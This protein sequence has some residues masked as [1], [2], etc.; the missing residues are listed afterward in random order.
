MKTGMLKEPRRS[1]ISLRPEEVQRLVE[2]VP[3][4]D[5]RYT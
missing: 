1:V 3:E 4:L 5:L 2:D